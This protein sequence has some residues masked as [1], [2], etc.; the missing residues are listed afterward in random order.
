[1]KER[2]PGFV[3]VLVL[4]LLAIAATALAVTARR[5][6]RLVLAAV[7]A[8]EE[9]QRRWLV[10][11][12]EA[13][14]LER[15]PQL[16]TTADPPRAQAPTPALARRWLVL[17]T[18]HYAV[19]LKVQDE[20]AKLNLNAAL[21]DAEGSA[22]KKR[23]AH[24]PSLQARASRLM[25]RPIEGFDRQL[26]AIPPTWPAFVSLEQV[27][28]NLRPEDWIGTPDRDAA[29]DSGDS[30]DSGDIPRDTSVDSGGSGGS[31]VGAVGDDLTLWG[32][33]RVNVHT[34]SPQ[35]LAAAVFPDLDGARLRQVVERRQAEPHLKLSELLKP[36]SLTAS[37][38]G[39][40]TAKLSDA[41]TCYSLWITLSNADRAWYF[42][43]V[44]NL[45][46][47]T[48]SQTIRLRW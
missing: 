2:R 31:G 17:E 1:M 8:E 40:V 44:R 43:S 7:S 14:V 15:A 12:A 35:V 47:K 29:G 48:T 24:L 25:I 4:G 20:Q 21:G 30:G 18:P 39:R 42:G 33:G 22:L 32:E 37:Q 5:H 9:L 41:S 13:L 16:L 38:Q 45:A 6:F 36:L 19:R 34:A 46:E 10:R 23:L 28:P 3:L 27:L 11:S 26:N